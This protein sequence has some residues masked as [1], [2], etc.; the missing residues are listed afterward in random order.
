MAEVPQIVGDVTL[1]DYEKLGQLFP[2]ISRSIQRQF[3]GSYEEFVDTLYEDVND[4]VRDLEENPELQ[5][6]ISEDRLTIQI[7]NGLRR[8]SYAAEHE[9]KVGGHADLI[10]KRGDWL[11]L[12]E[13]KI[14]NDY[15]WLLKGF[16]QLTT[17]YA[18]GRDY[19]SQGGLIIYVTG[20][21][22]AGVMT[23]WAGH[24]EEHVDSDWGLSTDHDID[25]PQLTFFSQHKHE[26]SGLDFRVK[27][28]PVS[29]YFEPRDKSA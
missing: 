7:R 22:T 23:K 26:R 5:K 21:N 2:H 9:T 29:L 6:P 10:V 17:R 24:L 28:I 13:A 8:L 1:A 19:S 12:G 25:S 27:H 11:W 20:K 15:A 4:I 14:H 18:V 16:H 3:P